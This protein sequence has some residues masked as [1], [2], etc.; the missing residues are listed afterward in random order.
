[1]QERIKNYKKIVLYQLEML[2]VR[3]SE[4]GYD[5]SLFDRY[6]EPIVVMFSKIET[7][8]PSD[9]ERC[10]VYKAK[11]QRGESF[12]IDEF[13]AFIRKGVDLS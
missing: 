10:S 8:R 12:N 1:M 9:K 4:I 2:N 11:L 6:V 7:V 3:K 13:E 5:V